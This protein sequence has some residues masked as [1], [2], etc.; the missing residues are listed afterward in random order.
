MPAH[1]ISILSLPSEA[2]ET[3]TT[4]TTSLPTP[5]RQEAPLPLDETEQPPPE[6]ATQL[7][8]TVTLTLQPSQDTRLL[9]RL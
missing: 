2:Q 1:L 3:P 9:L 4:A 8:L 5:G 6:Y 7:L